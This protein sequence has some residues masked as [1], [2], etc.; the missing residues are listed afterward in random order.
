MVCH[1]QEQNQQGIEIGDTSI[2]IDDQQEAIRIIKE[3]NKIEDTKQFTFDKN[4]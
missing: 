4:H 2:I 1:L 3:S